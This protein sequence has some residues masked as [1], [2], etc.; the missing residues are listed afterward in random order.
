MFN[1]WPAEK[2]RKCTAPSFFVLHNPFDSLGVYIMSS[3]WKT[4]K[5]QDFPSPG[6]PQDIQN[7]PLVKKRLLDEVHR[8]WSISLVILE[9]IAIILTLFG[10]LGIWIDD[11]LVTRA[12]NHYKAWLAFS[13][14]GILTGLDAGV[15]GSLSISKVTSDSLLG[16]IVGNWIAFIVHIITFIFIPVYGGTHATATPSLLGVASI[17]Q[18]AFCI[19]FSCLITAKTTSSKPEG[20]ETI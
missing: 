5:G 11:S 12:P 1:L 2:R 7:V 6:A 17:F 20:Y 4:L 9:V 15:L 3:D 14:I 13:I 18:L 8:A 19:I 10:G 16:W